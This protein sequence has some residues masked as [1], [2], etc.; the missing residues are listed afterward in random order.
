MDRLVRPCLETNTA[1]TTTT[2][3][4]LHPDLYPSFV[5][6]LFRCLNITQ[7]DVNLSDDYK[8]LWQYDY[9]HTPHDKL[10]HI[11]YL[12]RTCK[13][14]HT[15]I[16]TNATLDRTRAMHA[17]FTTA[18]KSISNWFGTAHFLGIDSEF[19]TLTELWPANRRR[20]V[21][22]IYFKRHARELKIL[23]QS[24]RRKHVTT[25]KTIFNITDSEPYYDT[26]SD[27]EHPHTETHLTSDQLPHAANA[28]LNQQ[29]D[30]IV[31]P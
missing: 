8:D 28:L 23:C 11:I 16:K 2:T 10:P 31:I 30:A 3:N 24:D 27:S 7:V 13:A 6:C 17:L 18:R 12:S 25:A 22:T 26:D 4:T 15:L 21:F 29:R 20:K 1:T 14:M 9:H 19:Y 5:A